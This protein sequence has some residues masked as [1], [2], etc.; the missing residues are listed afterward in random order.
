MV[1]NVCGKNICVYEA[2]K[3]NSNVLDYV[4]INKEW[5][6]FSNKDLENHEIII[7]EKCYDDFVKNLK[8]PVHITQRTQVL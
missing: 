2:G 6:F 5:G 7:C 8:V 4:R 1:C 3:D